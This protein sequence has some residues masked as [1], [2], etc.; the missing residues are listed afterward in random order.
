MTDNRQQ[1]KYLAGESLGD[2]LPADE[3]ASLDRVG[4]LL[5]NPGPWEAP[6]ADGQFRLLAAATRE[7][8]RRAESPE[9]TSATSSVRVEPDTGVVE[10]LGRRRHRRQRT[11]WF[12]AGAVVAAAAAALALV[13][14]GR[15]NSGSDPEMASELAVAATYELSAT[16]LDPDAVAT[17][18]VVPTQSGVEFR[19]HLMGLDNSEGANYYTAWLAGPNEMIPLGSFHWRKG[20]LPIILWS[21]VDD[22]A[23]NRFMV[24]HQTK[25]DGGSSS[26][27][28]VLMGSVPDLGADS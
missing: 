9:Q 1:G 12:G 19:L 5:K 14:T 20:G 2:E 18:D 10:L 8:R 27:E 4:R 16:A 13:G 25:G 7:S 28:V 26:G 23:Y 22:P 15:L 17:V 3:R 21:G 6:A 24:T 11:A